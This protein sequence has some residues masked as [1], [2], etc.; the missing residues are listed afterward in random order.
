MR[1]ISQYQPSSIG[2]SYDHSLILDGKVI[3]GGSADLSP[4]KDMTLDVSQTATE[5]AS[6]VAEPS[7]GVDSLVM[8]RKDLFRKF[9]DHLKN[10]TGNDMLVKKQMGQYY[11][12]TKRSR[13][14]RDSSLHQSS[15]EL[16]RQN[17]EIMRMQN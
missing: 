3:I 15:K 8:S 17:V 14:S 2:T 6:A 1:G 11:K 10:T 7:A 16:E 13:F 12:K 5:V 4:N 9:R